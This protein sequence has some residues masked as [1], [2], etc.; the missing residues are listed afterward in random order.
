MPIYVVDQSSRTRNVKLSD[1]D[2]AAANDHGLVGADELRTTKMS[3]M[4]LTEADREQR[5]VTFSWK[6]GTAFGGSN[7]EIV[8]STPVS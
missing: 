4:E 8:S 7:V 6:A 2:T 3:F 5:D 1:S